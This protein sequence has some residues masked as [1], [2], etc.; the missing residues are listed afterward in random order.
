[1][2]INIDNYYGGDVRVKE[3]IVC[4]RME[5]LEKMKDIKTMLRG[6]LSKQYYNRTDKNGEVRVW[7]PYYKLQC[8]RNGKNHSQRIPADLV[9]LIRKDLKEWKLFKSL[10]DEFADITEKSSK[11]VRFKDGEK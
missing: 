8:W 9:E 10:C 3:K 6:K 4:Q 5:I 2:S 11:N 7:G 1:L